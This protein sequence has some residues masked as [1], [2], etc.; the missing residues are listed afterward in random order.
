MTISPM[1]LDVKMCSAMHSCLFYVLLHVGTFVL[2]MMVQVLNWQMVI[3]D[4]PGKLYY[5]GHV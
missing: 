3:F 1:S 2:T 5:H 4:K